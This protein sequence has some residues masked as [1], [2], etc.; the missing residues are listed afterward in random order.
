MKNINTL[1]QNHQ[2][3]E[4]WDGHGCALCQNEQYEDAIA[5]FDKAITLNLNYCQAWNNRGNALC[6]LG[7]QAQALESYD[8]ALAINPQY[9]QA[10]F[11][12]G[13]LLAEMQAYGNALESYDRAI[14]IHPDPR[15]IHA[16]ENIWLKKKLFA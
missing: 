14:S 9:H 13:L 15:Y 7:R 5:A 1:D 2:N 4:F 11:N 3:P 6:G 12:R 8:K 16:K 10:W